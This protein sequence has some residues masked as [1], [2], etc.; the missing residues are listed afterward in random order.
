MTLNISWEGHKATGNFLLH[1]IIAKRTGQGSWEK[2][3]LDTCLPVNNNRSGSLC[4]TEHGSTEGS[5]FCGKDSGV[6][7][8][9]C[10]TPGREQSSAPVPS[11]VTEQEGNKLLQL[12]PPAKHPWTT[13]QAPSAPGSLELYSLPY[14]GTAGSAGPLT[15][16]HT[17]M[18]GAWGLLKDHPGASR[19][20]QS[21]LAG[22][23][24]AV[25]GRSSLVTL[26]KVT[27]TAGQ[28]SV[29]LTPFSE[30]SAHLH[31]W[32]KCLHWE[33]VQASKSG[34][35]KPSPLKHIFA[36]LFFFGL[37]FTYLQAKVVSLWIIVDITWAVYIKRREEPKIKLGRGV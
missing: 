31:Y 3:F 12:P 18:Q 27:G 34:I 35:L 1:P 37:A 4:K 26:S 9:Q 8:V 32:D 10:R 28:K 21:R 30:N 19:C 2:W 17:D 6:R 11:T 7:A 23:W 24:A 14:R 36:S 16:I 20:H 29:P 33:K 15:D 13:S 25:A 22:S 5:N